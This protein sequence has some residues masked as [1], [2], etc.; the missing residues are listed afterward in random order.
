MSEP[1]PSGLAALK[2]RLAERV[3]AAVR[4]LAPEGAELPPPELSPPPRVELGDFAIPC[5]PFSRALRRPP[6]A[7]A[8]ALAE[9]LREDDE[10]PP[11]ERLVHHA[12]AAGPYLNVTLDRK[13]LFREATA[14][15]LAGGTAYGSNG[16]GGGRQVMVEFSSPNTNKPQHLGHL[17]NNVL[18][19]SVAR[20]LEANGHRVVRANLVNDRGIH[21]CKSMVAYRRWG[22]GRTPEAED[23]K[24]DHFV[25]RYYVM[26]ERARKEEVARE[27][28]AIREQGE[29]AD[30]EKAE[31][32]AD[33]RSG[34][35][36]EARDLLRRWEAGDARVRALWQRMNAWVLDGFADTYARMGIPFDRFYYES[37]TYQLGREV[38]LAALDRGVVERRGDGSVWV[39]L[40]EHDLGEKLLLR[41]DGTTVYI[42]QDLGTAV[43][44]E[45][46]HDL[47]RS[48]Y[49]VGSEQDHHFRLLFAAL[50]KMG[51]GFADHLVHL[52][53]GMVYLPEGRMKT[54]EGTVVDADDLVREVQVEVRDL[55][56]ERAAEL[57]REARECATLIAEQARESAARADEIAGPVG[58]GALRFYLLKF[59]AR[60]DMTFDPEESVSLQGD[61][62]P[63]VQYTATRIPSIE[64]KAR[65]AGL[66]EDEADLSLLGNPEEV[67]LAQA[68]GRFPTVVAE[69]GRT[70]NP[71]LVAGF[72]LEFCRTFN[73]FYRQHR[74]VGAEPR[75]LG[76]AR[77]RLCRACGQVIRNGLGLLGIEV[78]PR[79]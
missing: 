65:A 56:A 22:E 3:A 62:G 35:M 76:A 28:A 2:S 46:D 14:D 77:L 41:R 5:F 50:K 19:D 29:E 64:E 4:T 39:D 57:E 70:L 16:S 12:D 74:V 23:E 18:G 21:I 37:E 26:F 49:V 10:V 71:S 30:P 34:L 17:R 15:V 63:Y 42:T 59:N 66:A 7:I 51:F 68:I 6:P 45:R 79:M 1:T 32:L 24:G 27:L 36:R 38:V 54:R 8:Q 75:A 44:K 69:A 72:L 20:I 52:S 53:Y 73:K 25:G 9:A 55:V 61:T 67:G 31:A 33:T 48:V 47:V 43:L 40:G 78:P 60:S 11:G 58:L 13:A